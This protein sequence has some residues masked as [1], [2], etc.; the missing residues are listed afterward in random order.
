M[1][2]CRIY[3]VESGEQSLLAS[4][5]TNLSWDVVEKLEVLYFSGNTIYYDIGEGIV[6]RAIISFKKEKKE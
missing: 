6:K 2:S 5:A 3:I 4:S 1:P